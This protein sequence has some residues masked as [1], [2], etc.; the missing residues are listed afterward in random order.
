VVTSRLERRRLDK[1][2]D[3]MPPGVTVLDCFG[4]SVGPK[5][6]LVSAIWLSG[7]VAIAA[8]SEPLFGFSMPLPFLLVLTVGLRLVLPLQ[9]GLI[10][11][12]AGFTITAWNWFRSEPTRELQ[13]AGSSRPVVGNVRLWTAP[14]HIGVQMVWMT[15]GQIARLHDAERRQGDR[16]G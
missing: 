1:A 4:V 2:A 15:R 7:L 12:D 11:S 9:N 10:I 8:V 16:S 5:P 13:D 6:E 3:L 14:V